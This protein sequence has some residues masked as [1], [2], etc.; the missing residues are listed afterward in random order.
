[1]AGED[2]T[3]VYKSMHHPD[4]PL[5]KQTSQREPSSSG[6]TGS[7]SSTGAF[8]GQAHGSLVY[9][10]NQGNTLKRSYS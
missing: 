2:N 3:G 8:M 4:V 1:M 6:L 7:G 10:R 5:F 9:E